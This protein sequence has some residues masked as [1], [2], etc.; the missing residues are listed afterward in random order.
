M[1]P[2]PPSLQFSKNMKTDKIEKDKF[3]AFSY[4]VTDPEGDLLFEAPE[5]APD[6]IVYGRTEGMVPGLAAVLDGLKAGDGF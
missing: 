5:Q 2:S 6:T 4:K 3:V 1:P